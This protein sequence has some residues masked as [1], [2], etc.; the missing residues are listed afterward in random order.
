MR[1]TWGTPFSVYFNIYLKRYPKWMLRVLRVRD[2]DNTANEN[3]YYNLNYSW[4]LGDGLL[5]RIG[6]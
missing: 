5:T 4:S 3:Y 2:R 1:N 6:Q